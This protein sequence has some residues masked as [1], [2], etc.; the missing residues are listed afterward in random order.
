MITTLGGRSLTVVALASASVSGVALLLHVAGWLPMYFLV[1]LLAA[2]SIALLL[3]VGVVARRIDERVVLNRLITGAWAGIVATCSYD[4]L[5]C[6]TLAVGLLSYNPFLSHP[7]FGTLITGFP[8][9]TVTSIVV[10]WIYHFWNGFGFGIMYAL[11]AGPAH[12]YYALG[13]AMF[14]EIAW[15]TAIPSL[16]QF[17][18]SP[19]FLA[20]SVSGHAAY[21]VV[22]G[23]LTQRFISA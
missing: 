18:L 7:V 21:G 9:E 10:G 17:R 4:L 22:L 5:R 14:L 3:I 2:P 11:I 19:E 12:W 16:L 13:W 1:N 23:L 15:L 20:V 8:P 6:L